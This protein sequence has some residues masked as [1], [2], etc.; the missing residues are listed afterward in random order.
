VATVAVAIL[1]AVAGVVWA[2]AW[3]PGS[4]GGMMGRSGMRGNA[5]MMGGSGGAGMMAGVAGVAGVAGDGRR[6]ESLDAAGKRAQV[7]GDQ[8]GLR[9]GEVMQ[10]SNGF[11]AELTGPDGSGA[12]EVLVDRSDG[13]VSVE[14]GPAMMWNTSYG[15][16]AGTAVGAER[17]SSVQA[18]AAAQRWL[19]DQRPGLTAAEPE[20]F[21]GYFTLHTLRGGQIV[22]MLSVNASTA[23]VWYHT[24]HG[25]FV[26]MREE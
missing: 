20:P 2:A 15:M 4:P 14:Y 11:Y 8:L 3:A 12:T 25:Q 7:L 21:P 5:G 13:R 6:V 26:A 23:A 17:I 9:V 19:D 24:W 16:H 10:F 1:I 22:G 18:V